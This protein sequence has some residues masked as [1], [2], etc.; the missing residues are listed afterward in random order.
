MGKDVMISMKGNLV[1][2][3]ILIIELFL[4]Y[5]SSCKVV[6]PPERRKN[7]LRAL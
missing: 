6:F 5:V 3:Q 2:E 4:V 1:I 7:A